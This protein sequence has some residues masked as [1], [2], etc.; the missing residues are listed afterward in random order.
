MTAAAQSDLQNAN[1]EIG[2][3][4]MRLYLTFTYFRNLCGP[5]SAA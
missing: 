4:G 3:P 5:T 2:V 1:R